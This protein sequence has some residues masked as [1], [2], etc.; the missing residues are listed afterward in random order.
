MLIKRSRKTDDAILGRLAYLPQSGVLHRHL[1]E[2]EVDVVPVVDGVQE[3]RLCR[4]RERERGAISHRP[5]KFK[6]KV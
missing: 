2:E 1:A 4:E 6:F 5:I 3:V